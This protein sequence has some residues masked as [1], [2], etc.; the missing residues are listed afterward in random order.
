[1]HDDSYTETGISGHLCNWDYCK[2]RLSSKYLLNR[3]TLSYLEQRGKDSN[4]LLLKSP[5][6]IHPQLEFLSFGRDVK[7]NDLYITV[8]RFYKREIQRDERRE[9]EDVRFIASFGCSRDTRTIKIITWPWQRKSNFI[10]VTRPLVEVFALLCGYIPLTPIFIPW[11]NLIP[12]VY[13]G[14]IVVIFMIVR[15]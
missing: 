6:K 9:T 14:E 10:T 2:Q 8:E 5:G 11:V 4:N 12:C 15:R 7:R 3:C 1:M 13:L